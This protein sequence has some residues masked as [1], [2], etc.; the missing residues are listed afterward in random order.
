ML[1]LSRSI[2][3]SSELFGGRAGPDYTDAMTTL[4]RIH[5]YMTDRRGVL[6]A[7]GTSGKIVRVET[8]LPNGRTMVSVWVE[9]TQGAGA[10]LAKVEM[11]SVV[12]PAPVKASA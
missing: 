12:G 5:G 10:R 11:A 1:V 3:S 6:L 9:G 8:E 7:D 4:R 2:R